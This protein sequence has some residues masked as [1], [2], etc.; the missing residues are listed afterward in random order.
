MGALGC[1]LLI[2]FGPTLNL[3]HP[4]STRDVTTLRVNASVATRIWV[5]ICF[6]AAAFLIYVLFNL[7]R[8]PKRRRT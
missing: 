8:E 4:K 6:F 2:L 7:V 3:D 1:R 5:M